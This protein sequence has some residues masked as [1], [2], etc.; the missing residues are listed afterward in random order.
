MNE[1]FKTSN[2]ASS[3]YIAQSSSNAYGRFFNLVEY[4]DGGMRGFLIFPEAI[5]GHGWK[6]MAEELNELYSSVGIALRK[7]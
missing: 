4:R 3:A 1:F 5:E 2:H 6:K 7:K